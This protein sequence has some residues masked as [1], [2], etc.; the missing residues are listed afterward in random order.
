MAGMLLRGFF[1]AALCRAF[2]HA[3]S[4]DAGWKAEGGKG[5]AFAT[6][7]RAG[8]WGILRSREMLQIRPGTVSFSLADFPSKLVLFAASAFSPQ[9]FPFRR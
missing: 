3:T 1:S 6:A 5:V 9:S 8:W 2:I 4:S 7:L